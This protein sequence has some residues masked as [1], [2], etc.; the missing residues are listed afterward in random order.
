M[1]AYR[2]DVPVRD[3]RVIGRRTPSHLPHSALRAYRLTATN[4]QQP[5]RC[6]RHPS[7]RRNATHALAPPKPNEFDSATRT[8]AWRARVGDVV[9]V[10]LGIGLFV[11][12]RR[13]DPAVVQRERGVDRLDA[14][15]AAEQV[16]GHRLGRAHR[17]ARGVLA[18]D[19]LDRLRLVD[20]VVRRRGAVR[21]DV[22]DL[23]RIDAAVWRARAACTRPRRGRPAPAR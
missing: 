7:Q 5:S 16:A 21:V 6:R 15:G 20:V 9:E 14:A 17:D 10:A 12:D 11:V 1:L 18:E 23:E 13:R 3:A 8:R 4:C 22:V 2:P 19:A